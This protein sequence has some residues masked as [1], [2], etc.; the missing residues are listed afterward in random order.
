MGCIIRDGQIFSEKQLPPTSKRFP[1]TDVMAL[2]P[3]GRM[4]VFNSRE[5]TAEEYL[6]MGVTSTLSFGPIMLRNGEYD[7]ARI[8]QFAK[9]NAPRTAIGMIE[10]GHYIAIMVEGRHKESHGESVEAL[11]YRFKERGVM[12][13][14]NLDGGET[15]CI[16]FMG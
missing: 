16:L 13:A 4:E 1:P 10:P 3:D 15:A 9:E 12:E 7:L 14:I 11:T 6:A 2:F 5:H 8:Q